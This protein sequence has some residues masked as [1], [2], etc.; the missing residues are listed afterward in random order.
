MR[1]VI[2]PAGKLVIDDSGD[3]KYIGAKYILIEYE[4]ELHI[5]SED[6]HYKSGLQINLLGRRDDEDLP[7][8]SAFGSKVLAVAPNGTLEIHGSHKT[9]WT[10]L[11]EHLYPSE[12]VTPESSVILVSFFLNP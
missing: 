6:C 9:S 12:N 1:N 7:D 5:G 10:R 11:S 2:L 8:L 3:D 4:G